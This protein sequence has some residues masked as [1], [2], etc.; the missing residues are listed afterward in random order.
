MDLESRR[1]NPAFP[2]RETLRRHRTWLFLC[3]ATIGFCLMVGVLIFRSN[4]RNLVYEG[5]P[6]KVWLFQLLAADP[7][8]QAEAQA[9]LEA[10]GTNAVPELIRL[11]R[12][13]D[14]GWRTLIWA[15]AAQLPKRVRGR[16][17]SRIGPTN[18]CVIRPMAARA[19]GRL[20]P[21][22]APAVPALT[23]MLRQG[24]SPYEEQEAAQTLA[25]IGAPALGA[26][27]DVMAHEKG[28]AGNAAAL[29]LL[30]RYHWPGPSRTTGGNGPGDPTASAR[31]QAVETIG[32]S[33]RADEW[34]VKVLARAA[35]DPVPNV[36][37][38][39]L[40]ALAR[41]DRNPQAALPQL[42]FCS[43]DDS[44]VIREWSA[45]ILGHIGPPTERAILPLTELVQDKEASVRAVAQAALETLRTRSATNNPPPPEKSANY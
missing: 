7:K 43:N 20:G 14:A 9:A 44:P 3:L 18:A 8:A 39:A 21:A 25:Q 35:I 27:A 37:L 29:A 17:L 4:S 34:V 5:K 28:G 23:Q 30:S 26:L 42:I 38:A 6:V 31:Q 40:K 19:L 36:R 16:L 1:G 2:W 45:R 22:A 33:D 10:L 41:A 24:S 15:H 11:V 13:K 12:T 32:A